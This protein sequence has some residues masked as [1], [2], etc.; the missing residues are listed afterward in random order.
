MLG[1][2]DPGTIQA[3]NIEANAHGRTVIGGGFVAMP[4]PAP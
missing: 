3:V 4:V 2:H 1:M